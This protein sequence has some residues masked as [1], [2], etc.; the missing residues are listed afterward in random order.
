MNFKRKERK[1]NAF[2]LHTLYVLVPKSHFTQHL[3]GTSR[4]ALAPPRF[5]P[6]GDQ[7]SEVPGAVLFPGDPQR[8]S[9]Q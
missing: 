9:G 5:S 3:H 1:G 4:Y 7:Y 8:R 6:A 2:I